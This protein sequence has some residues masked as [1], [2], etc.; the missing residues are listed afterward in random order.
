M[1]E[2]IYDAIQDPF[3]I[4]HAP[5]R[6][7]SLV[8]SLTET[9]I[10]LGLSQQM[11][12]KTSFCI[13]PQ[14][15]VKEIESI[16]GTKNFKLERII[17]L[18]ADIVFANMEENTKEQI[19]EL[20]K[21]CLVF[22]TKVDQF[23]DVIPLILA[24]GMLTHRNEQAQQISKSIQTSFQKIQSYNFQPFKVSYLIWKNP[25]MLAASNTFIDSILNLLTL[26]NA[27]AQEVRYPQVEFSQIISSKSDLIFLSSEPYPFKEKHCKQLSKESK[28]TSILVDGEDFSWFGSRLKD[29]LCRLLDFRMALEKKHQK[30]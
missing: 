15:L 21:H 18:K 30:I 19:M 9:L 3:L 7:I 8:P 22:V 26:E 29:S 1:K 25:Y 28:I 24:M 12:G 14:K 10:D 27:F 23:D 2:T 11:V 17:E 20:K 6:I 13:H 16:G 5:K 4:P